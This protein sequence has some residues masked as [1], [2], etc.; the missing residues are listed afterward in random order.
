LSYLKSI[1]AAS[2]IIILFTVVEEA[3]PSEPL[4]VGDVAPGWDSVS[5][6]QA[7]PETSRVTVLALWATWCPL[8]R[9]VLSPHD[10]LQTILADRGVRFLA[11]THEAPSVVET[12]LDNAGW[13]NL[14]IGC[15][16][17][18]AVFSSYAHRG[19]IPNLP[20]AFVIRSGRVY[21]MGPIVRRDAENPTAGFEETLMA[22]VDDRYDLD[23]EIHR[24]QAEE[25]LRSAL[26]SLYVAFNACDLDGLATLIDRI[27]AAH[28][29]K[30]LRSG[31]K[32]RLNGIAWDLLTGETVSD[33]QLAL[34]R[35]AL[36]I[37]LE[38][39]GDEDAAVVDT[40]AR[41][42][43]EGGDLALAVETQRRAVELARGRADETHYWDVLQAY[44]KELGVTPSE[45]PPEEPLP[46]GTWAR[47]INSV[48]ETFDPASE[49]ILVRPTTR[50]DTSAERAW[51][52]EIRT[53][54]GR[55]LEGAPVRQP[56]EVGPEERAT[57]VLVLYGTTT[58]NAITKWILSAHRISLDADGIDVADLRI[59][60]QRPAMIAC[61]PNPD[62]P[63]LPVLLYT[64]SDDKD[65][66]GLNRFFHGPTQFV[67]GR[68]DSSGRPVNTVALDFVTDGEPIGRRL[69]VPPAT[70]TSTDAAR[71]LHE[72]HDLLRLRYAGY[73][74]LDWKMRSAGSSWE[75][76]TSRFERTIRAEKSWLWVDFF[77]LIADYLSPVS[78]TH[79]SL[80]GIGLDSRELTRRSKRFISS[81]VPY[82]TDLRIQRSDELLSVTDG[83]TA[84][85][86]KPLTAAAVIENPHTA[87][88]DVPY[89]FPTLPREP[90]RY[91]LGCLTMDRK[92]SAPGSL[93]VTIGSSIDLPLHR[94]RVRLSDRRPNNWE[95]FYPPAVQPAVLSVRT[96]SERRLAGMETTADT[97][98]HYDRVIL[99][100]RG[101]GG[102]SDS[103]AMTWCRN[104]SGQA[105]EWECGA[106]L[107]RDET[108]HLR[109]W[110]SWIGGH[111]SDMLGPA[112]DVPPYPGEILVLV[113][114]AVASSGETFTMLAGQITGAIIVG[115]NTSGCVS[116]G[117]IERHAPLTTSRLHL[118]FGRTKFVVDWVE[119][120][121]EGVG[122]FP[123]YWLDEQDPVAFIA[124]QR[125]EK[126]SSE[127]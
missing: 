96:M 59:P 17:E 67:V 37:S 30:N 34:A 112:P 123:D 93:S 18:K 100:L 48:W 36:Q 107:W 35:R 127:K 84:L 43:Y 86:G 20:S 5:W 126:N 26:D 74:D 1:R 40:H 83:P 118:T 115:E 44:E 120:N 113:D 102:G 95:V 61:V 119:P 29:G 70:L 62:N 56:H 76:H 50:P 33:R 80:S 14:A 8:S 99:D 51:S 66:H 27:G 25:S 55:F 124:N 60:I 39:G 22:I 68:W 87:E 53:I 125:F 9:H 13:G 10:S 23:A 105:F 104:F 3:K 88:P 75:E 47:N 24:I 109:R 72:L 32:M 98:R 117:N 4:R 52:E 65:A 42:L 94:G 114:K 15:D 38:A 19:R 49:M 101:N 106:T 16:P 89:L 122:F 63:D 46:A 64:A 21:W 108:D 90:E 77:D 97:L 78:D 116:Y 73:D 31:V 28:P 6:L 57:R 12:F 41:I 69:D 121:R 71:D 103:P 79:F 91:L 111:L 58:S 110:S 2:A 82:F 11:I 92:E 54:S 7:V 81:L 45:P 85:I